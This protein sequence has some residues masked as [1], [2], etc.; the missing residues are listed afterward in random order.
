[1]HCKIC[2]FWL[3]AALFCYI[4]PRIDNRMNKKH[5]PYSKP[6]HNINKWSRIAYVFFVMEIIFDILINL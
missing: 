6:L 3:L 1:M 2:Y 4:M 5:F